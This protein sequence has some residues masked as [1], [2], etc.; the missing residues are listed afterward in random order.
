MERED[1]SKNILLL[2]VG[3]LHEVIVVR[4]VGSC[5]EFELF[6]GGYRRIGDDIYGGTDSVCCEV[7]EECQDRLKCSSSRAALKAKA[8]QTTA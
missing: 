3:V 7:K 1:T 4:H 8:T 6:L 2:I 5:R